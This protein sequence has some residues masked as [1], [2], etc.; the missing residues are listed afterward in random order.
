MSTVYY[1]CVFVA[2][3]HEHRVLE[4]CLEHVEKISME[5]E[6]LGVDAVKYGVRM[7]PF[8]LPETEAEL[9]A[10]YNV[11]YS[12]MGFELFVLDEYVN[13]SLMCSLASALFLG[14]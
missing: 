2:V 9:V 1:G 10:G 4:S 3:R 6:N 5:N 13:M 8:D 7:Q 11:E 14:G 12:A